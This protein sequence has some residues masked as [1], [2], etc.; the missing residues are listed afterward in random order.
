MPVRILKVKNP[1]VRELT[2][3]K[4]SVLYFWRTNV[5]VIPQYC[6]SIVLCFYSKETDF[7]YISFVYT[8]FATLRKY[9][10]NYH[11]KVC[12]EKCK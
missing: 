10:K 1:R 3:T 6:A 11:L 7:I 5:G 4:L 12:I 2:D 8:I 9:H